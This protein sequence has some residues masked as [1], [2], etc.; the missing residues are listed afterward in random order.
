MGVR[1]LV[2]NRSQA[3]SELGIRHVN[4]NTLIEIRL[5][6]FIRIRW[7]VKAANDN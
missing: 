3:I 4:E 7:A 2:G 5:V 1:D 6:R